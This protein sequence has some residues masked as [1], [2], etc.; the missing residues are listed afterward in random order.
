MNSNIINND[1]P[2]YLAYR[3]EIS[4][5]LECGDVYISL[6]PKIVLREVLKTVEGFKTTLSEL[7]A[8]RK[9]LEFERTS[10]NRSMFWVVFKVISILDDR[11]SGPKHH[12]K[13]ECEAEIWYQ[14]K[15][16]WAE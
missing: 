2:L 6:T 9:I 8:T 11:S 10:E 5:S 16:L 12:Y 1:T 7:K 14:L 4:A 3:G 13:L 15:K